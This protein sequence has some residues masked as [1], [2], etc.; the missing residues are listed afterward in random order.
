MEAAKEF[1]DTFDA[2]GW[3][4][5]DVGELVQWLNPVDAQRFGQKVGLLNEAIQWVFLPAYRARAYAAAGYTRAETYDRE[6]TG[7]PVDDA[8]LTMMAALS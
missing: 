8:T 3:S 6:H 2:A 4:P 7:E 1:A 5:S